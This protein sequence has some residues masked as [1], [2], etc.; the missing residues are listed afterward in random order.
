MVR[1]DCL[2]RWSTN[3]PT[4][5]PKTLCLW[6]WGWGSPNCWGAFLLS[7][8]YQQPSE[9]RRRRRRCRVYLWPLDRPAPLSSTAHP[10]VRPRQPATLSAHG[11]GTLGAQMF[12]AVAP[13]SVFRDS[14]LHSRSLCA[15]FVSPRKRDEEDEGAL[16]KHADTR[17]RMEEL[18]THSG[19]IQLRESLSHSVAS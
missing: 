13:L 8:C 4:S 7:A 18:V 1:T 3:Q 16:C 12:L 6:P 2:R 19:A 17:E 11:G 9:R 14:R 10:S 5:Q 15:F